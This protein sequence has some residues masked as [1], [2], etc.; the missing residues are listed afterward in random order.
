[1]SLGMASVKSSSS[2]KSALRS[3][4]FS[5]NNIE[6]SSEF[7]DD[8]SVLSMGS[9]SYSSYS[10]DESIKSLF[11]RSRGYFMRTSDLGLTQETIFAQQFLDNPNATPEPHYHHP[12][13][14][15]PPGIQFNV[16]TYS[17][18]LSCLLASIL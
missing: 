12:T 5:S 15:P 13:P 2:V 16:S 17:A 3:G 8:T 6:S 4:R 14:H 10:E 7:D 18:V 1:M 9:A 11:D